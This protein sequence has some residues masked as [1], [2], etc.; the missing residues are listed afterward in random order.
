MLRI[1]HWIWIVV[2]ILLLQPVIASVDLG[3]E[4]HGSPSVNMSTESGVVSNVISEISPFVPE[5]FLDS[6]EKNHSEMSH[7]YESFGKTSTFK[8]QSITDCCDLDGSTIMDHCFNNCCYLVSALLFMDIS[9]H[10]SAPLEI[11]V[12][13]LTQ[14][15][16]LENPPPI[17]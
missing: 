4:G 6:L 10:T 12:Q 17:V 14:V 3:H 16:L 13:W 7:R 5:Y 2:V 15:T 8:T 11:E 1:K 9:M